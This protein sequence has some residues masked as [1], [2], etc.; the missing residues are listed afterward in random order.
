MK[1]NDGHNQGT[2]RP[3]YSYVAT[4]CHLKR[5]SSENLSRA[6]YGSPRQQGRPDY[7]RAWSSPQR[8]EGQWH[9]RGHVSQNSMGAPPSPTSPTHASYARPNAAVYER[10]P[11]RDHYS[12][13]LVPPRSS[14]DIYQTAHYERGSRYDPTAFKRPPPTGPR[15][16][17]L[18]SQFSGSPAPRARQDSHSFRDSF[19][20]P[21]TENDTNRPISRHDHPSVPYSAPTSRPGRSASPT[22][23]SWERPR[24]QPPRSP[25]RMFS[26][27]HQPGRVLS[28]RETMNY[29]R[30][31][32]NHNAVD[33]KQQDRWAASKY[34][35]PPKRLDD[36]KAAWKDGR[37]P[38]LSPKLR[39]QRPIPHRTRATEGHPSHLDQSRQS[40]PPRPLTSQFSIT[41]KTT[42]ARENPQ[43]PSTIQGNDRPRIDAPLRRTFESNISVSIPRLHA[44]I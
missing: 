39:P 12:S 5:L 8:P 26:S 41:N 42:V 7:S 20:P 32:N 43:Q 29:T 13:P 9:N 3:L 25:P 40:F 22:R 30:S 6:P 27:P 15:A 21:S 18:V 4:E 24:D 16:A 44:C 1:G 28:L 36:L 33:A 17:E 23:I 35:E 37:L 19:A 2:Q 38:L 31:R 10:P 14:S 11:S 34:Q